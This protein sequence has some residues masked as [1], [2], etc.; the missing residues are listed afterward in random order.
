MKTP[1]ACA[2]LAAVMG[3]GCGYR[4]GGQSDMM[5]KAIHTIA[6]PPFSNAT[7]RYRLARSLPEDITREFLSRTHYAIV[8]D[9]TQADAVLEG[10]VANFNALPTVSDPVSGRATMDQVVVTLNLKLTDRR[11]GKVLFERKGQEFWQRYEVALDPNQYFDE[12]GTAMQ[13]ISKSVAASVVSAVLEG[14]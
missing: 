1:A 5:P 7:I 10:S 13:R 8:T 11:T 4:V 12:S 6:I 2:I 14:F 3:A 9:A